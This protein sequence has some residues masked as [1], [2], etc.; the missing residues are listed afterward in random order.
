MYLL[1]AGLV[2]N[3]QQAK[4]MVGIWGVFKERLPTPS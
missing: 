4:P 2:L 3:S 1:D